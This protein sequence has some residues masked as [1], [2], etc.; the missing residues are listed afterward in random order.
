V[1]DIAPNGKASVLAGLQNTFSNAGGVL[2]PIVTGFIVASTGSFIPALIASGIGIFIGAMIY[3]F[4]LKEIKPLEYN[5][6]TIKIN[7]SLLN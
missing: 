1:S 4:V 7:D 2:G 5:K 6:K 3:L